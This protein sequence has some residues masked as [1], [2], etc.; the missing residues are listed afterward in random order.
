MNEIYYCDYT[1]YARNGYASEREDIS[2]ERNKD[3]NRT[4]IEFAYIETG[5]KLTRSLG[6]TNKIK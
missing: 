2:Y 6:S 3:Y 5:G 4:T 1:L